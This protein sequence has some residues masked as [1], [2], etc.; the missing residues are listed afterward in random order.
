[1]QQM[2]LE[3]DANGHLSEA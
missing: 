3:T 1:M 2:V